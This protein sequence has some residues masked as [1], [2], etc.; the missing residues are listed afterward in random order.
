LRCNY[1]FFE[2]QD[3]AS[4]ADGYQPYPLLP[5]L[6]RL[7]DDDSL[8]PHAII[9][10]GG[11]EPTAYPE[12]DALLELLLAHGTFHYLHTN[13]TP[14]PPSHVIC[15]VDAAPPHT[16]SRIKRRASL[17]RVWA[18]LHEYARL[19]ARV[20][21]KYIVKNDNC[22]DAELEAFVARAAGVGAGELIVDYDYD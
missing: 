17:R 8:A 11:G 12:F 6:R 22:A 1:C 5:V 20:T 18:T 7:I 15:S 10:W 3:P 14:P 16:Y 13:A 21:L 2:T 4:F 19:G 9:D